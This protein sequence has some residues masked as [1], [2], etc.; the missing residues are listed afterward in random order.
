MSLKI[1]ALV[2]RDIES[3]IIGFFIKDRLGQPLFGE[4]TFDHAPALSIASGG[5]LQAEFVFT[6]PLLPNGNYSMTVS[7]ADGT[8]YVHTQH[9]W[10]HEALIIHVQSPKLRYGLV[11]IPFNSVRLLQQ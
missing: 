6:L 8:P 1:D 9:H 5:K 2:H 3:P 7:I 10:I 11:G 4:N